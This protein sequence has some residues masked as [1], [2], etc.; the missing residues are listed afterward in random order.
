MAKG[1][2][3]KPEQQKI[4]LYSL[5]GGW[6]GGTQKHQFPVIRA[7]FRKLFSF[8]GQ[9]SRLQAEGH[10]TAQALENCLYGPLNFSLPLLCK[11]GTVNIFHISYSQNAYYNTSF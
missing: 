2:S 8:K 7:G 11:L 5:L 6:E 1:E 10:G 3:G 4:I 9:F